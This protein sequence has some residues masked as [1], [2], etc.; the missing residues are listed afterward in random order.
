MTWPKL[1]HLGKRGEA[2]MVDVSDKAATERV[3]VAEGRVVMSA[4]DARS[5]AQG[6]R[7]EGRR[8]RR[9]AHRRHHGGEEDA[10][11]DPALPSARALQGRGRHRRRTRSCPACVVRATVQGHGPDRRRD[12]GA[13]RGVGRVPD[14]LRHGEGGRARHAHRGHPPGR[15]ARRQ[16]RH[17]PGEGAERWRCCR[18]P[19]RSRACSTA[20][21]PLPAETRAA[22]RRARP[23]ARRRSRRAAH[24][25][26]GRRVRDGRLRG[27]RRGRR[28][29][30]GAR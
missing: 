2:R 9:R 14:H 27:A 8:A 6:Q 17:L 5:R 1:T 23:R 22:R 25:A 26:A 20:P 16:V 28:E 15:E 12:G 18:S 4:D 24:A 13:D 10:R 7:Q 3:A 30:A 21:T 19:T 29:R 11:A